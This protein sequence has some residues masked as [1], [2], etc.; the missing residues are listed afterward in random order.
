VTQAL[1]SYISTETFYTT[2]S[3]GIKISL[4]TLLRRKANCGTLLP[5]GYDRAFR[6]AQIAARVEEIFGDTDTA[7]DW[8]SASNRALGDPGH[9]GHGR[10][11]RAH[12]CT[13][14]ARRAGCLQ[15]MRRAGDD[16]MRL[17]R[18]T[19]K[20]F[21]ETAFSREGTFLVGDRWVPLGQRVVYASRALSLCVFESLVHVEIRHTI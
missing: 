13:L 8:I 15:L 16:G 18:L 20:R 5:K 2:V 21:Q 9:H 19:H 7:Q 6:I 1:D 4:R 3:N 12:R 17:W 11:C 14:D 10:R